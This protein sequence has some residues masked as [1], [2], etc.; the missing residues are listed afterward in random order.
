M[1]TTDRNLLERYA[2]ARR[3]MIKSAADAGDVIDFDSID[4]HHLQMG[5]PLAIAVLLTNHTYPMDL[6]E[7]GDVYAGRLA[8]TVTMAVGESLGLVYGED[9]APPSTPDGDE[10]LRL[11]QKI[12]ENFADVAEGRLTEIDTARSDGDPR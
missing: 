9:P 8:D 12:W 6:K 10:R 7:K 1:T 11:A 5:T 3:H 4:D 2:H